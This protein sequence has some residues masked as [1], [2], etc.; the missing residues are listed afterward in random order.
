MAFKDK[1]QIKRVEI[2]LFT[3]YK[4]IKKINMQVMKDTTISTLNWNITTL[5]KY[6]KIS[7]SEYDFLYHLKKKMFSNLKK[8]KY[9][10]FYKKF[11]DME[12][13]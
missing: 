1:Q 8:F 10:I 11:I 9:D 4:N 7:E 5:D 12:M 3:Y 2:Y 6:Y 13:S